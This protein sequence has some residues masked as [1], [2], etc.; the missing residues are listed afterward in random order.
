MVQKVFITGGSRGIG[1]A[2]VQAFAQNGSIVVFTY[3]KEQQKAKDLVEQLN[4]QG[5]QVYSI[6]MDV[7]NAQQVQE[8]FNTCKKLVGNIDVLIN[9]AGIAEQI[10]FTD[11]T[12]RQWDNMFNVHV[13]GTFLCTQQVMKQMIH[14]KKGN[15]INISSMWGQ[16]GASCEVHYSAA[17]AAIIGFTKALAKEEGLSGVRVNCIAPGVVQT[18]MIR[19]LKEDDLNYLK[20]EIPLNYIATAGDIAKVALFLASEQSKYITG[21]VI[22]VNGGMVV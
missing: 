4:K 12:E 18:D 5:Q 19:A 9:N 1:K 21:Q 20:E 13:K 16:V 8:A 22:A 15:I 7:T 6:K 2:M 11:I 14:S 17:K 3:Y 10:L